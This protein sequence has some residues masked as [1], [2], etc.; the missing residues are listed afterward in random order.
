MEFLLLNH[1]IKDELYDKSYTDKLF[2]I[3]YIRKVFYY[4]CALNIDFCDF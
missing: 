1:F 4:R 2:G 3:L